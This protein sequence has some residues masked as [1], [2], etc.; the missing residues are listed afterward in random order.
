MEKNKKPKFSSLFS[1]SKI[2]TTL[3]GASK[4]CSHILQLKLFAQ[5]IFKK[6]TFLLFI[7]SHRTPRTHTHQTI[8]HACNT[9]HFIRPTP[10]TILNIV[11]FKLLR[12]IKLFM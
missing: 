8:N 11:A 3:A 9:Q 7:K 1:P 10:K 5:R 6:L 12:H 4:T 2:P